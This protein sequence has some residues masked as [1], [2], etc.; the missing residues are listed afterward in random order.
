MSNKKYSGEFKCTVVRY[1]LE[2]HNGSINTARHF[3]IN[4]SQVKDWLRLFRSQGYAGLLKRQPTIQRTLAFKRLVVATL[5][6]ESLSYVQA[7]V[8]FEDIA[9][10]TILQWKRLYDRGL[11]E[12]SEEA[13]TMTKKVYRP[14]RKKP[15][16]EKTQ[17]E[18]LRELQYMRAEVAFLKKW[19][20]LEAQEQR[21]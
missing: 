10:S 9:P 20:E 7:S 12:G 21:K 17:E 11:L 4:P 6:K 8:L 15:D 19:S 1:Y 18:L 16:T 2:T 14:D 5:I 3:S 13:L